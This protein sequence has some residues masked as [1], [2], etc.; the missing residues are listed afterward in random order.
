MT[1]AAHEESRFRGEP[2]DLYLFRYGSAA[3][4]FFAYTDAERAIT[5]GGIQYEPT[6][7]KR[8]N[9]QS[10]GT[11]DKQTLTVNT[12]INT[13][14]SNLFRVYPP[15]QVVSL[16]IRQGHANDD[17]NQ[18]LVI[19]SGRVLSCERDGSEAA[20][21]CESSATS[22]KRSMLRRNYQLSCPHVLYGPECR[23][24]K[25]AATSQHQIISLT[26][27]RVTLQDGWSGSTPPAKYVGGMIE[28]SVGGNKEQRTILNVYDDK[29]L[30]L[31]GPT[32][33]LIA[34]QQID[35]I[36][37]CN[38]FW[39]FNSDGTTNEAQTDCISVHNNANNYGGDPWIPTENPINKNPFN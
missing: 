37:G 29:T 19:W 7:I 24:N 2:V 13:G 34:G 32:T 1:F 38:H 27:T 39:T 33:G 12:P 26:G 10:S 9:F 16:V 4:A 36:K 25:L 28:W 35:V 3:N 18:F 11:L 22:M 23:A 17:D 31:A 8:G 5:V 15:G 20:L 30:S 6:T 14:I 21:S